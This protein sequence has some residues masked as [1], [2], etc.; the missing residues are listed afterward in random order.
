ML[1]H[2][3][4]NVLKMTQHTYQITKTKMFKLDVKE[5]NMNLVVVITAGLFYNH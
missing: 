1:P 3:K 4:N 5:E 2:I